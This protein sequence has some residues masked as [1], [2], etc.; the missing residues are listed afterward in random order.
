[1]YCIAINI[2]AF[3]KILASKH[4]SLAGARSHLILNQ[5]CSLKWPEVGFSRTTANQTVKS[6]FSSVTLNRL[7]ILYTPPFVCW[8]LSPV[9]LYRSFNN[10]ALF[11]NLVRFIPTKL[12]RPFVTILNPRKA[13]NDDTFQITELP[14]LYGVQP[15]IMVSNTVVA[16]E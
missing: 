16:P 1:M 6:L 2:T 12:S 5:G 10:N 15:F 8:Q 14:L 3:F 9:W 4:N 13:G 11:P 7:I